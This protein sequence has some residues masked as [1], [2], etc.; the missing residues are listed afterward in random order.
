VTIYYL[1][2]QRQNNHNTNIKFS[3]H[4][5]GSV[6]ANGKECAKIGTS[7]LR[8]GGSAADAAISTILCEGIT[9][10]LNFV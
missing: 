1:A 6:V 8:Q 4:N 5:Y 7:I 2:Q 9:C 10:K 3:H